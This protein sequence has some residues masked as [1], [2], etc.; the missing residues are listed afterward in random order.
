M[1]RGLTSPEDDVSRDFLARV[2]GVDVRTIANLVAE[3][4]D[5]SSRGKFPLLVC[6]QWYVRRERE[7]ARG[8]K[9]LN[10]LDLARQRKTVA[11]ARIAELD[12]ADREGRSIP[13]DVHVQRMRERLETV[14]GNVKAINRYQPDVKAAIT[15]DAA[16]ALLDRMADEILAELFGLRESIE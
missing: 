8:A 3:G 4:M 1:T 15:D 12:L 6:V 16:D 10:D 14:A 2:L 11:E 13:I 5:K 7:A 9:G